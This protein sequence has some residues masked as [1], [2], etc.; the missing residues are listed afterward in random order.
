MVVLNPGTETAHVGCVFFDAG[1]ALHLDRG[2]ALTLGR[3]ETGE[4]T[5]IPDTFSLGRGW[6]VIRSNQPVMPYGWYQHGDNRNNLQRGKMDFYPVDA[7]TPK[8]WSSFACLRARSGLLVSR[9]GAV[10]PQRPHMVAGA[11][12]E[13]FLLASRIVGRQRL[14]V[15]TLAPGTHRLGLL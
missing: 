6:M 10:A 5:S 2:G 4:C 8:A 15:R 12:P 14:N 11:A 9:L 13:P 7:S 3:G 1:G